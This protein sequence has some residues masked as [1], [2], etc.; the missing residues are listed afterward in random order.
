MTQTVPALLAVALV[1]APSP[2]AA[3]SGVHTA[4]RAVHTAQRVVQRAQQNDHERM[5]S[6]HRDV[7]AA[8]EAMAH[9][10]NAGRQEETERTTRTLKIGSSGELDVTN[11]A[12]DIVVTAGGGNE[13]TVEIL[14]TAR[15]RSSD[16]ARQMLS[17]VTVEVDERGSRGEIRARYPRERQRINPRN[18]NVSVAYTIRAPG[19]TRLNVRTVSG[20]VSVTGIKGDLSLESVSGTVTIAGA[21]QISSAKSVSGNVVISDTQVDGSIDAGSVS[22]NVQLRGVE[23]GRIDLGSVSGNVVL[24]DVAAGRA[25]AQSVSGDV[26]YSGTLAKDGRYDFQSHSGEVRLAV[27]GKSG[28]E[29]TA[30]SFSGSIRSDLQLG[31][32]GGDAEDRR[33][34]RRS[35]RGVY[36]DGSAFVSLTTFSGSVLITRR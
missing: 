25:D 2:A 17:L 11:I 30:S 27:A 32:R 8:R 7:H 31:D 18:I 29:V 21:A 15:A 14:K 22:G 26:S 5:R 3:Q 12:G 4:Q 34:R 28:F 9:Q 16:E 36:G 24:E 35:L 10:R 19:G 6:V 13:A 23:A 33:G 20:S 1:C